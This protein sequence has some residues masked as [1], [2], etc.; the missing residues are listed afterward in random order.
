V[1]EVIAVRR[2]TFEDAAQSVI[3]YVE[4]ESK[5]L[6]SQPSRT[7]IEWLIFEVFQSMAVSAISI[8]S[9]CFLIE[10]VVET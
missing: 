1:A 2:A 4:Q 9:I 6:L 7:Y 5:Q 3:L 10:P 8:N